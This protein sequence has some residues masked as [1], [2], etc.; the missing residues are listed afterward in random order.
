[1]AES[2]PVQYPEPGDVIEIT[3]PASGQKDTVK[4]VDITQHSIRLQYVDDQSIEEQELHDGCLP[5]GIS[6]IYLY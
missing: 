1:M 2:E 3:W 4:I 5:F 6:F